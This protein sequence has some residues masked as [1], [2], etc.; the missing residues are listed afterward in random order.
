M[1]FDI[2]R[3]LSRQID[4]S[5]LNYCIPRFF[6]FD[7]LKVREIAD[8]KRVFVNPYEYYAGSIRRIFDYKINTEEE[9]TGSRWI[10]KATI[11][12]LNL[13]TDLHYNHKGFWV[14]DNRKILD[15]PENGSFLKGLALLPMIKDM[16]Y[17]TLYISDGLDNLFDL[18]DELIEDFTPNDQFESF[19]EATRL[20]RLR[21]LTKLDL[22]GMTDVNFWGFLEKKLLF[23]SEIYSLDG[24]VIELD[25]KIE[26]TPLSKIIGQIKKFNPLFT[27]VFYAQGKGSLKGIKKLGFQSVYKDI[28]SQIK[29]L[30]EDES[31]SFFNFSE[32]SLQIPIMYCFEDSLFKGDFSN[33]F[34]KLAIF[35]T[36][37]HSSCIPCIRSSFN[38]GGDW[39]QA[40]I[41]FYRFMKK[42]CLLKK[43]YSEFLSEDREL[44]GVLTDSEKIFGR[45]YKNPVENAVLIA[46]ANT[47]RIR[48]HWITVDIHSLGLS[49]YHR[50]KRKLESYEDKISYIEV[51]DG[52]VHVPLQPCEGT[53]LTVR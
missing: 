1:L 14:P 37:F 19:I 6:S 40:S 8:G 3:E 47:D 4:T 20:L 31:C 9:N 48:D 27:F 21:I 15:F 36:V 25:P 18:K 26:L 22:T 32:E 34:L 2:E 50:V 10:K 43:R 35:N 16:G 51:E 41:E 39:N 23:L 7:G 11:F 45:V 30:K 42:M 24:V 38:L 33:D 28:H 13:K 49:H 5:M 46:L 52:Y 53:L 29:G 12:K 44:K 17:D